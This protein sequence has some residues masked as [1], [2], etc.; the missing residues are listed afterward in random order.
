MADTDPA[1]ERRTGP[2]GEHVA[3]VGRG[4]RIVHVDPAPARILGRA[5]TVDR[6]V[7]DVLALVHPDDLALTATLLTGAGAGTL[8]HA[9]AAVRLV[10]AS[11]RSHDAHVSIGRIAGAP[12]PDWLLVLRT[13]PTS[14]PEATDSRL[15]EREAR[16]R[17][18]FDDAP[19]PAALVSRGGTIL[20]ANTA[21]GELAGVG[22]G[23]LAGT[24]L[25]AL[26]VDAD[27]DLLDERLRVRGESPGAPVEVEVTAATPA[28]ERRLQ[29]LIGSAG[30][31]TVP[32]FLV[33]QAVDVTDRR[34][35]EADLVHRAFHD[36]LT[37]LPN[38]DLLLDRLAH[39]LA[40]RD[41]RAV[42]VLF[43]DLNRFKDVNDTFGHEAGD[44]LLAAMAERIRRVLRPADTVARFGGDEFVILLEELRGPTEAVD[45]ANRIVDAVEEPYRIG[46]A[47]ITLTAAI[48]VAFSTHSG[49][50]AQTLLRDADTAMYRAKAEGRLR[51][52]E[53]NPPERNGRAG[54]AST[55]APD[56]LAARLGEADLHQAFRDERIGVVFQ[57]Q[58]RLP[59]GTLAGLEALARWD[60][61]EL[62]VLPASVFLP[63]ARSAGLLLHL[64]ELVLDRVCRAAAVWRRGPDGHP[65]V[66]SFNL[67]EVELA[68]PDLAGVVEAALARTGAEPGHVCAEVGEA[69]LLRL[70]TT[71]TAALDR[72]R[73]IGVRISLDDAGATIADLHRDELPPVDEVKID[74]PHV[75]GLLRDAAARRTVTSVIDLARS[76]DLRTVAEGVEDAEQVLEL[77]T[78]GCEAGQGYYFAAPQ[79]AAVAERLLAPDLRWPTA[80][81]DP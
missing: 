68:R 51:L 25:H 24:P 20:R 3:L 22:P 15:A 70:G 5:I 36:P 6:T 10:D 58:V 49:P 55:P 18:A 37:G 9:A 69:D 33:V 62:G 60:H 45:V 38:R 80:V 66:V 63:L 73:A 11:G 57:P 4:D 2:Q 26:V 32:P 56:A 65:L 71:A 76:L 23:S 61:P 78:L 16:L 7:G 53:A 31:G 59:D 72:L 34:A 12:G 29:L 50:D 47:D 44:H 41:R 17:A 43:L 21:L 77:R 79:P 42:G 67:S 30:G 75:D 35:V 64:G 81:P 39:A 1:A 14:P 13:A 28:G 19:G 74:R 52:H 8:D 40:R 48:G 54:G 46:D 27:R